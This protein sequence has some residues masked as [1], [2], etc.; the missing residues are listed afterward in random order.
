ML[1]TTQAAVVPSLV[2]LLSW[3]IDASF[4]LPSDSMMIS[5]SSHNDVDFAEVSGVK[6]AKC[7][8]RTFNNTFSSSAKCF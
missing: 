5:N 4:T 8:K 2:N 3:Y 7:N 1:F 6:F